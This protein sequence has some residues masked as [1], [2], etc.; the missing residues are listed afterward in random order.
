MFLWTA[1][2]LKEIFWV[3]SS[4]FSRSNDGV[5]YPL[6]PFWRWCWVTSGSLA[7]TTGSFSWWSPGGAFTCEC[8]GD[9]CFTLQVSA[10][11]KWHW[12][13]QLTVLY[14]S[15]IRHNVVLVPSNQTAKEMPAK[16]F[17]KKVV[18]PYRMLSLENALPLLDRRRGKASTFVGTKHQGNRHW[19]QSQ[20]SICILF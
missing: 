5:R 11:W 9:F 7:G 13:T 18:S 8:R 16:S 20:N 15:D 17:D 12:N 14:G 3:F 1:S 2:F 6:C 10:Q 19:F 4:C